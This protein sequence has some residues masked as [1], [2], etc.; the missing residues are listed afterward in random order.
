MPATLLLVRSYEIPQNLTF[1]VFLF[2][3][4]IPVRGL[5]Q[6]SPLSLC[7][8]RIYMSIAPCSRWPRTFPHPVTFLS[9]DSLFWRYRRAKSPLISGT[10]RNV[11]TFRLPLQGRLVRYRLHTGH[12]TNSDLQ[13]LRP[14]FVALSHLLR[15]LRHIARSFACRRLQR[16]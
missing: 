6:P 2:F 16:F 15:P 10:G 13:W 7:L 1:R 3:G 8:Q 5:M 4:I 12:C 11:A 9:C 14:T